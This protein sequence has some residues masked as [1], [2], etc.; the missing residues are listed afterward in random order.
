M[1]HL[2]QKGGQIGLADAPAEKI[3]SGGESAYFFGKY[4]HQL[5]LRVGTA[6]G[7][8]SLEVIPN[9]LVRIEF[10]GVGRE[11]H[12][13]EAT[14]TREQFLDRIATVDL[15]VVQKHHQMAPNLTEQ[16]AQEPSDLFALNVVLVELAVQRTVK[17]PRA[18]RDP[19]D[20]RYAVVTLAVS[21][22][23]R[24]PD[25][26]PGLANRRNQEEAGFVDKDDMGRQPC[27]VFFT[28]GQTVRFQSAIA[29]SLRSTARRSGF[30]WLQPIW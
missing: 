6:V 7:Q 27:G 19:G 10:G 4:V 23:R 3:G 5:G 12:K 28:A 20:G 29:A 8:Q 26:A 25:R 11:R 9:P 14:G 30:W 24:L 21:N 16:V 1:Q 15:A 18:D 13:M 17:P 2:G 22:D